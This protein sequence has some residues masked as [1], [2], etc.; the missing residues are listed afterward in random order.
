MLYTQKIFYRSQGSVKIKVLLE[1]KYLCSYCIFCM[2]KG[3]KK[4]K[5]RKKVF[6]LQTI[7]VC[8]IQA[9]FGGFTNKLPKTG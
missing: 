8:A 1:D 7:S 4:K 9:A 3:E 5:A 2:P 6:L